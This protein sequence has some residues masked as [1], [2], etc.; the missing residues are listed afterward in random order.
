ML[1][2]EQCWEAVQK[3][4]VTQNG[5]FFVG[6]VTT[7]VYCLPACK[8]RLPLRENV[9][10]YETSEEAERDGLRACKRC[11]PSPLQ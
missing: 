11:R 8:S 1:N 6:V 4:D 9:R 10:F 2:V 7:G 5:R 3:R